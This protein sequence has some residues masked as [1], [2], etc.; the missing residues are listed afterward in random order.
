MSRPLLPPFTPPA[1]L[2]GAVLE[3]WRHHSAQAGQ[4]TVLPDGC[5]DLILHVDACGAGRWMVS[6]LA[7]QAYGVEGLA[8]EDWLGYRLHPGTVLDEPA[9]LHAVQRLPLHG[10]PQSLEQRVLAALG[11]CARR[12]ARLEEALAALAQAASVHAAARSLGVSER[13]LERFLST[14]TG[15]PPRYWRALARVRCAA[16]SLASSEPL[17]AIAAD[18]GYA[19]QAHFSRECH[20]WLGLTPARL[21]A[22]PGL[23]A[24]VH[25]SGYG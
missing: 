2:P 9:L 15:Q 5:R 3:R 6:P 18:A 14:G 24:T 22:S 11:D 4:T 7:Q 12:D 25:A 13:S 23:L 21:R 10:D 1:A 8:A 16:R 19:D 20:R 17:A